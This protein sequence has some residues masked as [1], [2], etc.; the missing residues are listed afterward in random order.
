M[1]ESFDR[2]LKRVLKDHGCYF[3]R[4]AKGSHELWYSPVAA[5][6]VVVPTGI[7]S[8]HTANAILKQAGL[9]K[10]F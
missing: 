5:R 9:G 6:H 10:A 3:V 1:G 2:P 7:D 4:S 8:R